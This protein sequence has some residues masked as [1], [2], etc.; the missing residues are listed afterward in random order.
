M[1]KEILDPRAFKEVRRM[2]AA[3]LGLLYHCHGTPMASRLDGRSGLLGLIVALTPLEAQILCTA[4]IALFSLQLE[5][6][7]EIVQG[8][9]EE[10]LAPDTGESD[11]LVREFGL[12]ASGFAWHLSQT[13][14]LAASLLL[15]WSR[16]RAR[17]FSS[18]SLADVVRATLACSPSVQLQ[19]CERPRFWGDLI[20]SARHK[21]G[22]GWEVARTWSAQFINQGR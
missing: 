14:L 9:A 7:Q 13:S 20:R 12:V 2:N 21:D 11:R 16:E 10:A 1:E 19:M 6:P 17:E 5:K 15:G 22:R 18:L 8:V 3:F 4:R